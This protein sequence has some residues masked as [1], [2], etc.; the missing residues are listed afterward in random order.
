MRLTPAMQKYVRHWGEMGTRWSMNRSVAQVHALLYL[1][2][3]PLNAEEITE[4]LEI[5][6]SNVS[7]SLKELQAWELIRL[8]HIPGDRRDHFEAKHD[9]WDMLM[10]IVEGRKRREI[11]PT[12]EVL[13][14]IAREAEADADTPE[15]ARAKIKA[16]SSFMDQLSGWY[17]QMKQ[18]PRPVLLKLMGLGA[19]ITKFVSR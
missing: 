4:T 16:M 2:E 1:A 6:R 8:V 13:R 18:I 5:A 9:P 10:L 3:A 12:T 11:D 17:A 7:N 15:Q 14:E 19:R